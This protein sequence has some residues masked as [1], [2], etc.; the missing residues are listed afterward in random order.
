MI[1]NNN[2]ND[3]ATRTIIFNEVGRQ[4]LNHLIRAVEQVLKQKDNKQINSKVKALEAFIKSKIDYKQHAYQLQKDKVAAL[5]AQVKSRS[6]QTS[7]NNN[8]EGF[9]HPNNPLM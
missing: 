6:S 8:N 4:S 3:Q 2:N 5:L 1:N 9:W 7:Q